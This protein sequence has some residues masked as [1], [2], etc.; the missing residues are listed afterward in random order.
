M[1]M[2]NPTMQ[3]AG[4]TRSVPAVEADLWD[5]E[6]T[7]LFFGGT[8]PIHPATLYRGMRRGVFPQPIKIGVGVVRWRPD[9]CRAAL[10]RMASERSQ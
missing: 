4:A 1:R 8:K 3:G 5:R 10:E 7:C 9:E 6:V 2:D